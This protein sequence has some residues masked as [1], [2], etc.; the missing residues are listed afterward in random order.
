[1]TA[2]TQLDHDRLLEALSLTLREIKER[3]RLAEHILLNAEESR[4]TP[5]AQREPSSEPSSPS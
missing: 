5:E 3:V 1:M 4:A 2:S